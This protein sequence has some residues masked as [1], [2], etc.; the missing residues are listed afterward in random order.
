MR[1]AQVISSNLPIL[2][3]GQ[4][5]WGATELIMDEYTK[6]LRKLGGS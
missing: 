6:N 2:P 4:R 3:T 1:I 5:G